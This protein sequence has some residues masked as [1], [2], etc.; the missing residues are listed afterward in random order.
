M[1]RE[2]YGEQAMANLRV[3]SRT[4]NGE[5]DTSAS[6]DKKKVMA[7]SS[8]DAAKELAL[9]NFQDALDQAWENR[10]RVFS[11][12]GDLR[13]FIEDLARQV[14]QGLL[15]DGVL[16]RTADSPKYGYTPVAQL[17]ASAA[18]FYE[19]LFSLLCRDPYDAVEAAAIAEYYINLTSHGDLPDLHLRHSR[20]LHLPAGRRAGDGPDGLYVG[21]VHRLEREGRADGDTRRAGRLEEQANH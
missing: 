10:Y 14:N 13:S 20:R 8:G 6:A 3:M 15:K 9:R 12:P 16:Y 2:C 7:V 11:N 5:V 19:Q 21:H 18:W 1:T 17:E 4:A